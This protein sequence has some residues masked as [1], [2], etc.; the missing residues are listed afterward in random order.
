MKRLLFLLLLPI[1]CTHL[2]AQSG[3]IAVPPVTDTIIKF[4]LS[5]QDFYTQ[6]SYLQNDG[7]AIF[8]TESRIKTKG[9]EAWFYLITG[10]LIILALLKSFFSKYFNDLFGIFFQATFRQKSVKEQLLQNN[11]ASMT[12]N[13]FFII[14]ATLFIYQLGNYFKWLPKG[15]MWQQLMLIALI[16]SIVYLTKYLVLMLCGWLFNVKEGAQTYIFVV[17]LLNKIVGIVITPA[18]IILALGNPSFRPIMITIIL[19]LIGF[20]FFYRYFLTAPVINKLLKVNKLH[21]ILYF[22]C[23]EVVPVILIY[24]QL[25]LKFNL[26]S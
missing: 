7:P 6:N 25:L 15:N 13:G 2:S 3:I 9:V 8:Y 11:L 5:L 17:F 26:S 22:L 4:K 12:L 19:L 18:I 1:F 14:S 16:L 20:L 10:L 24:K 21:L 23:I